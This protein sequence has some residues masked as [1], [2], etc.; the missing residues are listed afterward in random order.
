MS[1]DHQ[2]FLSS[3]SVCCHG[4][5]GVFTSSVVQQKMFYAA[6]LHATP[7]NFPRL[8]T[9]KTVSQAAPPPVKPMTQIAVVI[10]TPSPR[11]GVR[12]VTEV[13]V[14]SLRCVAWL[15]Q[16][17]ELNSGLLILTTAADSTGHQSVGLASK[18]PVCWWFGSELFCCVEHRLFWP[19][20]I[21]VIDRC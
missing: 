21:L 14:T 13:C 3:S 16:L 15:G 12:D 20:I 7:T 2:W 8:T 4:V 17:S 9:A 1:Y 6:V 11:P 18:T 19:Q 5:I 10:V